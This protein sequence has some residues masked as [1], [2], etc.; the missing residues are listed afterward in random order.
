VVLNELGVLQRLTGDY[1]AAATSHQHALEQF[2][3]F[4]DRNGQSHALNNLGLVQQLT[5][6]QK[7]PPQATS[8]PCGFPMTLANGTSKPKN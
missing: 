6:D 5:G 8:R 4:G 3:D 2:S 7:P 1:S